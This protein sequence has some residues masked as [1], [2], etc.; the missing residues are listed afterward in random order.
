MRRADKHTEYEGLELIALVQ[1][2]PLLRI[3]LLRF[4]Y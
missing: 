3:H 2:V 1:R 4:F